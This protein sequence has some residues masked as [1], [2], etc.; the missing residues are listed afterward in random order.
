MGRGRC[1]EKTL[2]TGAAER[3]MRRGRDVKEIEET[4]E[5]DSELALMVFRAVRTAMA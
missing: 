1:A 3:M 4:I 2:E 5:G